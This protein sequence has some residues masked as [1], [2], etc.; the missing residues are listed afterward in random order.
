M[1]SAVMAALVPIAQAFGRV[2]ADLGHY[3]MLLKELLA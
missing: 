1:T 3:D 2:P